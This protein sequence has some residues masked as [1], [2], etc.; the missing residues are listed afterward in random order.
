M[1]HELIVRVQKRASYGLTFNFNYEYSHNLITGQLN[2]GGPLTY[3]GST[4]D[5]PYNYRTFPQYYGRGD[6][7]TNLDMSAQKEFHFW[8][9]VRMQYRFEAYNLIN[10]NQFALP[11]MSPTST[12]FGV[13]T[14]SQLNKPRSF[15][16]GLRVIF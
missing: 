9:R 13:I 7:M 2:P 3:G 8:E 10:R 16:Q 6:S 1:F 12:S 5:Y 14:A 11:N 4:S 15:Q